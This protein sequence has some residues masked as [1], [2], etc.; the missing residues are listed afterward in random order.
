M[1]IKHYELVECANNFLK[2]N[3][4][5]ELTVPIKFNTRL[6]S[7]FGRYKYKKLIGEIS[8]VVIEMSTNFLVHSPREQIIDVLKHELVHYALSVKGKP[9]A[10]GHPV[11][12]NEL[13]RLGVCSTHT[14]SYVGEVHKYECSNC[15]TVFRR[16]RRMPKTAGCSCSNYP[17]LEYLGT[18][19]IKPQLESVSNSAK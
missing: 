9:F 5:M 11:F 2:E 16:R 19:T 1:N 6:K 14:Y 7:V 8:P 15:K 18:E 13:K 17:N 12:E 4:D 3:Y 10:D